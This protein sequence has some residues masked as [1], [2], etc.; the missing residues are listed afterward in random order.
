MPPIEPI[1]FLRKVQRILEEGDFVATYKFALLQALAD[2]SVERPPDP[3]GTLQVSLDQIAEKFIEYYWRQARPFRR[4]QLLLQSTG[5]QAAIVTRVREAHAQYGVSLHAARQD[6]T[7]WKALVARVADTVEKMPLWRLQ[8][9]GDQVDEFLYR[10]DRFANRCITLEPA[11]A[12]CF[13]S[14]HPFIANMVRGAWAEQLTRIRPNQDLLGE[15]GDLS[16]FLFGIERR[17]LDAYR[18]ILRQYQNSKCFY[19]LKRVYDVGALDHFIPW[20]RYPVDLGH[21]FVFTH[22]SCNAAKRDHLAAPDHLA[23]WNDQNLGQRA[24]LQLRFEDERLPHDADRSRMIA[25]WAYEQAEASS[26]RVWLEKKKFSDL[27]N[28]WRRSLESA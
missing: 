2:L 1:A 19:C 9:V 12:D 24:E 27:T 17:A 23:R 11:A 22:K 10:R 6:P 20:S 25:V 15:Q 21:N 18:L 3:D 28:D 13:R 8:I 5:R 16:E 7:G 14:F 26:S 4:G